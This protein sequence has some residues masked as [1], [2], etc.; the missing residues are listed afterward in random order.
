[1]TDRIS[2]ENR[3]MLKF[4]T[5]DGKLTHYIENNSNINGTKSS[6]NSIYPEYFPERFEI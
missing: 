4:I 2:D 6:R 1:M 5:I 3:L